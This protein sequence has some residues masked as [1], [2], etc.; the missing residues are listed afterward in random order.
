MIRSMLCAAAM[1]VGMV[2]IVDARL[3]A[4]DLVLLAA[5]QPEIK[6]EQ[7][8][9]DLKDA[10]AASGHP[11][12]K[13]QLHRISPRLFNRFAR[14]MKLNSDEP[15][16]LSQ[17]A[18]TQG[19]GNQWTLELGGQFPPKYL[20]LK[21]RQTDSTEERLDAFSVLPA[22]ANDPTATVEQLDSDRLLIRTQETW[23]V[24]EWALGPGDKT[25]KPQTFQKWPQPT[26]TYVITLPGFPGGEN[27]RQSL[28]EAL[29]KKIT[30]EIIVDSPKRPVRLVSMD[31]DPEVLDLG[32]AVF[33][34]L[35]LLRFDRLRTRSAD[36]DREVF[37]LFPLNA[38]Q[39]KQV[40]QR[41]NDGKFTN[42]QAAEWARKDSKFPIIGLG[43]AAET[44][45]LPGGWPLPTGAI[46]EGFSPAWYSVPAVK[47]AAGKVKE[48]SRA[49][50]L[51]D[52]PPPPGDAWMVVMY[53][54]HQK[55]DPQSP[56]RAIDLD[57]G[58]PTVFGREFKISNL[59][60]IQQAIKA[61][62]PELK[63][64]EKGTP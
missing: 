7:F 43:K 50:Q 10:L 20:W 26:P 37:V 2:V 56:W 60:E 22:V 28:V 3:F 23:E 45:G 64:E 16:V 18:I 15:K 47:D 29:R 48:F 14:M 57:N 49:M 61:P 31:L 1:W 6:K 55:E 52:T 13:F 62:A 9:Q 24:I 30:Q 19:E 59:A 63:S 33:K 38:E 36:E 42:L 17:G 32:S 8:E 54:F 27:E 58:G 44:Q 35:F 25:Q 40:L 11:G 53:M 46:H 34:N 4:R 12:A 51:G 39:T 5:V 41:L 21:W